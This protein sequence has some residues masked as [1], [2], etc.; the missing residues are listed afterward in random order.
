MLAKVMLLLLLIPT[1]GIALAGAL[2]A[3]DAESLLDRVAAL[4]FAAWV[5]LWL[6]PFS[7]RFLS[8]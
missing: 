3:G 6:V 8:R 5:A 7:V 1:V 2:M 4:V